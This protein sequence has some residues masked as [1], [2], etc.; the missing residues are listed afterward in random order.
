MTFSES[1]LATRTTDGAAG[2]LFESTLA[3]TPRFPLVTSSVAPFA[4]PVRAAERGHLTGREKMGSHTADSSRVS[5]VEALDWL[6]DLKT[7]SHNPWYARGEDSVGLAWAIGSIAAPTLYTPAPVHAHF[8][9]EDEHRRVDENREEVGW[10]PHVRLVSN[11]PHSDP[12]SRSI[13]R[14]PC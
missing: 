7:H 8:L 11:Q 14:K 12:H 5:L 3:L 2:L 10:L 1:Q 6:F 13:A 4:T 9:Q